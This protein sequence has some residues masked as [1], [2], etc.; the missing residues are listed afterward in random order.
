M[1][2]SAPGSLDPSGPAA[3]DIA[4]LWW[5]MLGAGTAVFLL[6]V[7]LLVIPMLRRRRG[8]PTDDDG[9]RADVPPRLANRL[10]IGLGIV[11][12]GI[13]LVGVLV[14]SVATMRDVSRAAPA[15]S[16]RIDVVGYQFWW[17]VRYPDADV[18]VA[19]ELH[20]PVGEPVEVRLTSADVIHSFW[21]PELHGKLDLLPDGTNTLVI[22]ADQPGSYGGECAEFCGIQ[23]TNMGFLVIA[24]PPDEFAAWLAG[25]QQP[26]EQTAGE[27]AA[28]FRSEGCGQCHVIEGVTGASA[29][30]PGPDLTHLSSRQTIASDTLENTAANLTE[31]L[32]DPSAVKP[33]TTMPTPELTAEQIEQLVAY[34][35]SL[36]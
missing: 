9:H 13:L 22:E 21:T 19:N 26:A 31:W 16:T 33:G 23:H 28:L 27:G 1:P 17:S 30:Q 7:A 12:T 8:T 5:L 4:G 34:L 11:M 25:Q 10:I 15:G 35:E 2:Q 36:E 6:V 24:E 32:R 29:E 14:V 18:T 20:I 3:R